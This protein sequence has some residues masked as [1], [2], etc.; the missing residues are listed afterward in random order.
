MILA[1][2]NAAM[3]A[4]DDPLSFM[5]YSLGWNR[6]SIPTFVLGRVFQLSLAHRR[7]PGFLAEL[8]PS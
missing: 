2:A 3:H 7:K 4:P 5:K 1:G 8:S 6:F